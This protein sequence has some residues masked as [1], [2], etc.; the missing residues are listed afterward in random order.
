MCCMAGL[1]SKSGSLL[2][3]GK[4]SEDVMWKTFYTGSLDLLGPEFI[5]F[6][7]LTGSIGLI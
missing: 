4:Y 6:D 7:F 5:S 1:S 2:S 3:R